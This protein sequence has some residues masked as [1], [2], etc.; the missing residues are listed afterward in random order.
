MTHSFLQLRSIVWLAAL[1][2][3]APNPMLGGADA[4]EPV[5][6]GW[7]VE[8]EKILAAAKREGQVAVYISGYEE[9]LP[10]FQKEYPEIK[11]MPTTGRGS[12][13]GQRLLAERR[14]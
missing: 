9:I 10:A 11:V 4:A 12:Q 2:I 7:Q 14:A 1:A 6:Q 13:I 8:W 5:K 3:V